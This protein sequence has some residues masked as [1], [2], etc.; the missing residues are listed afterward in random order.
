MKIVLVNPSVKKSFIPIIP[1]G[2]LYLVNSLEKEGYQ[3][4][5]IDLN[6]TSLSEFEKEI[7]HSRPDYIG[8]SMRN[9]AETPDYKKFLVD[10]DMCINIAQKYSKIILGGAGFSIFP[11]TL[12]SLY[13]AN[14][15]IVGAGEKAICDIINGNNK[16]AEGCV[17][18]ENENAFTTSNLANV[19]KKYWNKYGKYHSIC[20]SS[21]PIQT[22]RGCKFNCRY[23]TYKMI[24]GCKIQQ[25]MIES[26][27]EEIKQIMLVTGKSN[28]YFVDSIF[29]MDVVYTK[30]LL[31]AIIDSNIKITWK[32]CINPYDYD[33]ELIELMK[34]SGCD[35]CEVGIDSF[36]DL[37]LSAL[38]KNF[39]SQKAQKMIHCII[40]HKIPCS[41]SLILGGY[42][43]TEKSLEETYR[44]ANEN[45][46]IQKNAFIG[47]RIYPNTLLAKKLEYYSENEL[48]HPSATSIYISQIV[49]D[50]LAKIV[51]KDS[52]KSWNFNGGYNLLKNERM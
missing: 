51:F 7:R 25:R 31:K 22:T 40:G 36:S 34:K 27:I 21:I 12:M 42:G 38:G 32:C 8:V 52:D 2:I 30:K 44:V 47:E 14:Y 10:T 46:N 11:N 6:F 45:K 24:S 4:E 26:V 20:K 15:G 28:F 37:Q 1:I 16:I 9:I 35:Y 50:R 3:Y 5:I 23:C 19:M 29:N 49:K 39:N 33:D 43:E 18:C 41:I 13:N 17:L 48:F